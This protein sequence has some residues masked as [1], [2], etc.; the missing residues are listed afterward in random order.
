MCTCQN[1]SAW[2]LFVRQNNSFISACEPVPENF[3]S[4]KI[5]SL[6]FL[7]V[8]FLSL[9][10]PLRSE[11]LPRS[12]SPH[13]YRKLESWLWRQLVEQS[14]H[15]KNNLL[16]MKNDIN[17][18]VLSVLRHLPDTV[19]GFDRFSTPAA[20]NA[21][22]TGAAK[23]KLG[24]KTKPTLSPAK[25]LGSKMSTFEEDHDGAVDEGNATAAAKLNLSSTIARGVTA[26]SSGRLGAAAADLDD[27]P[28]SEVGTT[29]VQ[30]ML[31]PELAGLQP[32]DC[33]GPLAQARRACGE[34]SKSLRL[35]LLRCPLRCN[36]RRCFCCCGPRLLSLW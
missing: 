30:E 1:V 17:S 10:L 25:L 8:H 23:P 11:Y 2:Y 24:Q 7:S 5:S 18:L 20:G 16:Q 22:G 32:R 21:A 28:A 15:F 12:P 27:A 4:I 33:A 9:V 3:H 34:T 26:A 13:R 35:L 31:E 6:S 29:L 19:E 36:V 14:S